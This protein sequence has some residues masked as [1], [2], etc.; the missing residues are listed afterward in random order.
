MSKV[1][2]L[3]VGSE[4]TLIQEI[5][6]ASFVYYGHELTLYVYDLSLEVPSGVIKRDAREILPESEIFYHQGSVAA[7]SDCFRYKMIRD[8]G[9][10]WVDSDTVCFT[11]KFFDDVDTVFI[12]ESKN[13]TIYS[14]GILKLPQHSQIVRDLIYESSKLKLEN[15]N[16]LKWGIF[17][18]WLL[19]DLVNKH[20]LQEYGL[21]QELVSLYRGSYDSPK[22][23][24]PQYTDEILSMAEKAYCGTF[25]NSGLSLFRG[26]TKEDKNRIVQSSAIEVFYNKFLK[27]G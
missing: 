10:M 12:S 15:Y 26:F 16:E 17:G 3:W 24:D 21:E 27:K 23:W 19:T 6:W 14:Q 1:S 20:G 8:T 13:P 22:Y 9:A 2:S 7:F 11:D 4:F 18:P 5:S 25:Y